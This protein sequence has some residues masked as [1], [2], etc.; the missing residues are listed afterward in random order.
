MFKQL[1]LNTSGRGWVFTSCISLVRRA[2]ERG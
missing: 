1:Q 2:W